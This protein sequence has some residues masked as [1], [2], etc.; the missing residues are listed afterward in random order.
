MNY[1]DIIII[2]VSVLIIIQLCKGKRFGR[3]Q[4]LCTI[5]VYIFIKESATKNISIVYKDESLIN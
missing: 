2:V 1:Q 5:E 4:Y 3:L